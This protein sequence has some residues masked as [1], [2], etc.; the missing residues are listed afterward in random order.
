MQRRTTVCLGLS[1]LC[2]ST[3]AVV[4][5]ILAAPGLGI[6]ADDDEN[7]VAKFMRAKLGSSQ[8]VLE[9]LVVED[10]EKVRQ[11]AQR[12]LV[13]SKA[14]EWQVI[15]G[16]VYD[17]YSSEFQHSAKQLIEMAKQ[18]NID[19]AT[20]AYMRLTMNCVSCHKFVRTAQIAANEEPSLLGL[21]RALAADVA[22]IAPAA[23]R[24]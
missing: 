15:Q 2:L 10:F 22:R 19:G 20:L 18:K 17:Q 12:M 14:T 6:A 5:L 24:K 4:G 3:A 13:M 7:K 23:G 16:P 8:S 1:L 21:E 9:G 11:G